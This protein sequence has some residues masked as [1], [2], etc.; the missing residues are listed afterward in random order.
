[1]WMPEAGTMADTHCTVNCRL[2]TNFFDG[3]Q[4]ESAKN[5]I[6]IRQEYFSYCICVLS[7]S[8]YESFLGFHWQCSPAPS[9]GSSK[10]SSCLQKHL[11]LYFPRRKWE[12]FF[13]KIGMRTHRNIY[14]KGN[15]H[16]CHPAENS[17]KKDWKPTAVI[18]FGWEKLA[19]II[20]KAAKNSTIVFYSKSCFK[21]SEVKC[22]I[23]FK[24][25]VFFWFQ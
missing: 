23:C 22:K 1:M 19:A 20:T 18:L 11:I 8:K 17:K 4:C 6:N 16:C 24:F 2:C 13:D 3:A 25:A 14:S 10:S 15:P 21:N 7:E 12:L 9:S 5:V